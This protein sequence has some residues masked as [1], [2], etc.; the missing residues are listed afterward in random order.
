MQNRKIF[1][2]GS[3]GSKV[4]SVSGFQ[5]DGVPVLSTVWDSFEK[6]PVCL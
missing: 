4:V 1:L 5:V 2:K 6:N 3:K